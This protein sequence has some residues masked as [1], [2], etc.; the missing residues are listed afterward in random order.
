MKILIRESIGSVGVSRT[1][2]ADAV[3]GACVEL[4]NTRQLDRFFR[5]SKVWWD[6]SKVTNRDI[7]SGL[8]YEE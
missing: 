5:A 8:V 6:S 3:R 2:T 1:V 4:M 7:L